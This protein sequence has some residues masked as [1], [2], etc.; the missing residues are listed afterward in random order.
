MYVCEF[1]KTLD[2]TTCSTE[3]SAWSRIACA[4]AG[5]CRIVIASP[6]ICE[7]GSGAYGQVAYA[8]ARCL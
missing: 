6:P 1:W 2:L 8:C 3:R 5:R 7:A 4:A